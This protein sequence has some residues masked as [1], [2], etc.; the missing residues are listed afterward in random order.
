[1]KGCVPKYELKIYGMAVSRQKSNKL[2][3][4]SSLHSL[5]EELFLSFIFSRISDD[6]LLPWVR[7]KQVTVNSVAFI[8]K[9]DYSRFCANAVQF[10]ETWLT[11]KSSIEPWT[12]E[13]QK[14]RDASPS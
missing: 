9:I 1:M 11:K 4:I 7:S 14:K 12:G 10:W 13:I 6:L 5:I 8:L 3:K 2:V